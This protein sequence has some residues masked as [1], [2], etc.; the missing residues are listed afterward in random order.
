MKTI[1]LVTTFLL[2]QCGSKA[3]LNTVE[4]IRAHY[5]KTN[6]AITNAIKNKTGLFCN[7]IAVNKTGAP[8]ADVGTYQ[9]TTSFWYSTEMQVADAEEPNDLLEKIMIKTANA[10]EKYAE[11]YLFYKGE[12]VFY[13]YITFY[14]TDAGPQQDEHRIYFNKGKLLKHDVT[15]GSMDMQPETKKAIEDDALSGAKKLQQLFLSS[16]DYVSDS[17]AG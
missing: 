15:K 9:K 17:A 1:L 12:L 6:T 3:Q 14:K 2:L 10:S 8:W 16:N 4:K 7:E 5:I 13:Y 11:E